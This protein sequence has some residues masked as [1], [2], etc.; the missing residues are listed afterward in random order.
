MKIN[1]YPVDWQHTWQMH[2]AELQSQ[3]PQARI[4][5]LIEGVMNETCYP[6]LQR[7]GQLPFHALYSNTPSAD[8]ET[9]C[10]SPLLVEYKESAR[11]IWKSLLKKTD[12][13]PALSLIVTPESLAQLAE[14]LT[15]WCIVDAA[16]QT[17]ALSFADTRILP[18][19]FKVLNREQ[20]AQICGP[21]V[22]WQYLTRTA[23]WQA[24]PLPDMATPHPASTQAV[25]LNDEQCAQLM[26]ASEA[27]NVLFQLRRSASNLV[28][29][30]TPARAHE[31]VQ[32]WLNC[33]NHAQME[34]APE[35]FTLCQLGLEHPHLA[36]SQLVNAWLAEASQPCAYET[37]HARWAASDSQ[38]ASAIA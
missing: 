19:L 34:T 13:L 28:D 10:I 1:C 16:G 37:L 32:Y 15:P 25:S 11:H 30:H 2:L 31:L 5:A 38:S 18:E 24:L 4:Y 20:L 33:A 17:L 26:T 29:C 27:D 9:L 3:F 35:R 14:R 6:F 12:G 23:E 36:D 8:Q 21:T 7:S 22:Q